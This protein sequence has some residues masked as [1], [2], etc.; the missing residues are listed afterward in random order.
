MGKHG[1]PS[2]NLIGLRMEKIKTFKLKS[3]DKNMRVWKLFKDREDFLLL[4]FIYPFA[5]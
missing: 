4:I 3:L 5:F 1:V 2:C